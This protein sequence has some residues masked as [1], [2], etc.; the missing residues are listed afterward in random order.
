M[1]ALTFAN[2]GLLDKFATLSITRGRL[3]A[4]SAKT[5]VKAELSQEAQQKI[6]DSLRPH[7]CTEE[8]LRKV[9]SMR[10]DHYW[11]A[12]LPELFTQQEAEGVV[13]AVANYFPAT[14]PTEDYKL[15]REVSQC[16]WKVT[17]PKG[18]KSFLL[19]P[20]KGLFPDLDAYVKRARCALLCKQE[21]TG[22]KVV[23]LCA[24]TPSH[25]VESGSQTSMGAY[26]LNRRPV[27]DAVYARVGHDFFPALHYDFESPK[28]AGLSPV[29]ACYYERLIPLYY[30]ADKSDKN[31]LQQLALSAAQTLAVLHKH[32]I[33]VNDV[34]AENMLIKNETKVVFCDMDLATFD[35]STRKK[36]QAGTKD[37]YSPELVLDEDCDRYKC[38]VFAFCC[39]LLDLFFSKQPPWNSNPPRKVS[40]KVLQTY[41]DRAER[42]KAM[43]YAAPTAVL[44]ITEMAFALIEWG[45]HPDAASR[46][47]MEEIMNILSGSY[48]PLPTQMDGKINNFLKIET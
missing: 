37:Y 28:P 11:S 19:L 3:E 16:N 9:R 44:T 7:I 35:D 14:L 45:F 21:E 13:A 18:E 41:R 42:A 47:N 43:L 34:K 46:P 27:E 26:F 8:R 32:K 25:G 36:S 38:D 33:A 12:V 4:L 5:N 39:A 15:S 23:Q 6:L 40:P 48:S 17:F 1:E 24:L 10:Y 2:D 30:L 22:W 29:R 20:K 31:R